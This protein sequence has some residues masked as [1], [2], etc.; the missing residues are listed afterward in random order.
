MIGLLEALG[1]LAAALLLFVVVGYM[2]G[3]WSD[4][5]GRNF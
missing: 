3:A 5:G 2:L 4:K 1:I